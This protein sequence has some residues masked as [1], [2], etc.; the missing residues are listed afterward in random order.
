MDMKKTRVLIVE[1]EKLVSLDL[2]HTVERFGYEVAGSTDDGDEAVRLAESLRPDIVLMDIF[3]S[4]VVDG[5]DAARQIKNK[6][7]IPFIYITASADPETLMRVKVTQPYGYITKPFE[8]HEVFSVIETALYKFEVEQ[9]LKKSRE[10]LAAVLKAINDGIVTVDLA[11]NIT[12]MNYSAELF[13]DAPFTRVAGRNKDEVFTILNK[14]NSDFNAAEGVGSGTVVVTCTHCR[15]KTCKGKEINVELTTSIINK[16]SGEMSGFVFV[17]KDITERLS[18]EHVLEKAANEWRSTFDA[19]NSSIA[20]V[21]YDGDILRCNRAFSLLMKRSF[22]ECI[23][24]RFYS[25]FTSETLRENS[26][27]RLIS[28]VSEKKTRYEI[29]FSEKKRWLNLQIDPIVSKSGELLGG[30]LILVDVT[31][32][33]KNETELEK[34]R[35]HLEELVKSR[36]TE[37]EKTNEALTEEISIRRFMQSQLIQ[38]KEAAEGASRAKSEF[39]ANMSHELRTP[40]N[41]IIGFAKLLRMGSDEKERDQYLGNI[42][43]SGEH[44]LKLI[45]ELLDY[46]KIEAG[47]VTLK[48]ESCDVA[49]LIKASIDIIRVQADKK[50]I[51]LALRAYNG[52]LIVKADK[53][54]FQ[55]IM[56]NLLSNAV[57]FT[58]ESGSVGVNFSTD[59]NEARIEISD[60]GI[61]IHADHIAVIFEKFS[62][63]E[64]GLSRETQGTGL[65]LPITKSL[66]EAHGGKISVKSEPGKGS[67][68]A[69]T[70]PV[71]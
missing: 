21:D 33:M 57:K 67:I 12:F 8:V 50:K 25:F 27:D 34:Y 45:N 7:D 2:A 65:G 15:L 55:Q 60:T 9:E 44:L 31:E 29:T 22:T 20:L 40:L 36:T 59:K 48:I 39:L 11:G 10:W 52:Q 3:L 28:L 5:I 4:G 26:L 47:K 6:L 23:G 66:V 62:Q 30:I 61:G 49:D 56:L 53:Q 64:S 54:R 24:E 42:A 41:S 13:L 68:F 19:I 63:I 51:A 14:D 46:A 18:Y 70:I 43:N 35:H 69:F 17:F 37:L 71:A 58:P 16:D 1:D 32:K 38:A